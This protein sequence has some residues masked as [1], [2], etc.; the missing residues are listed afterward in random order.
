VAPTVAK[1]GQDAQKLK[2]KAAAA[3][4]TALVSVTKDVILAS[5]QQTFAYLMRAVVRNVHFISV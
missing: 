4:A 2:G 3:A 1:P 5:F